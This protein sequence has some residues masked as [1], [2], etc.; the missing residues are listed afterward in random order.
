MR[1]IPRNVSTFID[2]PLR[3]RSHTDASPCDNNSVICAPF[4]PFFSL[5]QCYLRHISDLDYQTNH[6]HEPTVH[7][8]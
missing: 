1:L 6:L 4:K 3:G 2:I 8:D 7:V 5:R